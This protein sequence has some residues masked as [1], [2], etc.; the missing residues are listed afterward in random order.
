MCFWNLERLWDRLRFH[1]NSRSNRGFEYDKI[2][3]SSLD[4]SADVEHIL[5]KFVILSNTFCPWLII[6]LNAKW[7]K[8][9]SE[10]T[11]FS[12]QALYCMYSDAMLLQRNKICIMSANGVRLSWCWFSQN[13]CNLCYRSLTATY[14]FGSDFTACSGK[15]RLIC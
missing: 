1:F 14:W 7:L 12:E 11:I 8:L 3:G 10:Y 9:Y 4:Y 15:D 5:T 13:S 6:L 2:S